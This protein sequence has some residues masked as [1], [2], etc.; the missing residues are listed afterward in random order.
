MQIMTINQ[1]VVDY[2]RTAY[3]LAALQFMCGPKSSV[4]LSG[5]C[6]RGGLAVV[7]GAIVAAIEMGFTTS[8][9]IV[10]AVARA[11]R[12]WEST[13]KTIL[14]ELGR[15]DIPD[16]LWSANPNGTYSLTDRPAAMPFTVFAS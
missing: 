8:F 11:T 6:R 3:H 2:G 4:Y 9:E 16:R 15:D 12:C 13:I 14:D 7:P 5:R 10:P 1:T